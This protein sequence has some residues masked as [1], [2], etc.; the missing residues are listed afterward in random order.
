MI[1]QLGVASWPAI[2]SAVT[3]ERY[4]A[5][6]AITP[7]HH[8]FIPGCVTGCDDFNS[9]IENEHPG[10]TASLPPVTQVDVKAEIARLSALSPSDYETERRAA[11]DRLGWRAT[12]LDSEVEKARPRKED[13]EDFLE[14]LEP[15]PAPV[16]GLVMAEK[17]RDALRRHV[18]FTSPEDADAAAL[19]AIGTYLMDVWRLWPKLLITSPTRACGK[20][21][22]LEVIEAVSKRAFIASSATKASVFRVIGQQRPTVLFDEADVWLAGDPEMTS[23]LN[24]SHNRRG[25]FVVRAEEISRKIVAVRHDVWAPMAIA[26]IGRPKDT[27][28]SR[29]IEVKLRRRLPSEDIEKVSFAFEKLTDLRRQCLRWARDNAEWVAVC[30]VEPPPCGDDRRQDNWT[31][32][33]RI[34]NV[35]SGPWPGRAMEAYLARPEGVEENEPAGVMLLQDIADIFAA[36]ATGRLITTEIIAALAQRDD[37]PWPEW[38]NGKVITPSAIGRLLRPF[39]IRSTQWTQGKGGR[40]YERAAI[41]AAVTR[42]CPEGGRPW[43]PLLAAVP[44]KNT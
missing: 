44:P 3:P 31:P 38:S 32:L 5:E 7:S 19:W 20:T 21:T 6:T 14:S 35:L 26:C 36:K 28:V 43:N 42:Y 10:I 37:R 15:W 33:W 12:V 8:G 2:E 1:A 41:E 13:Q 18:V 9:L 16:D 17:I 29:S 22:L 25:A 24:C 11:A 34:A 30:N 4:S 40:G 39:G 27:L 23:L